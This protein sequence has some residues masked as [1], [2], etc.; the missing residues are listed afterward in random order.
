ML[1]EYYELHITFLSCTSSTPP[2]HAILAILWKNRSSEIYSRR[3]SS[4]YKLRVPHGSTVHMI[5]QIQRNTR[6]A[7]RRLVQRVPIGL[8]MYDCMFPTTVVSPL[9][10]QLQY[11]KKSK[12]VPFVQY[13][14]RYYM[15]SSLAKAPQTSKIQST[16]RME[17]QLLRMFEQAYKVVGVI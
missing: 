2:I 6:S 5:S 16:C 12:T 14:V 7:T 8:W 11:T 10:K 15:L 13:Q 9:A 17:P 3:T 1:R 4:P